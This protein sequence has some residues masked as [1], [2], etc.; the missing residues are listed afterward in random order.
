MDQKWKNFIIIS[1]GIF[2]STL[3]GSILNIANPVIANNFSVTID[4]VKWVTSS[5][6]MMITASLIFFGRLG[7]KAGSHRI[8][9]WGFLFFTLGSLCC[10]LSPSLSLLILSRVFQGIGASMLMA[11]G[12]GIISNSFPPHERGKALGLS[13]TIVGIGNMAGPSLG[14]LILAHFSWHTIFL[15]NI[16]F[17]VAAIILAMRFLEDQPKNP[18][19]IGFDLPG[20]AVF[21]VSVLLLI[22]SLSGSE[23][24]KVSLL[25]SFLLF[26]IF[27]CYLEKRSQHPMLDFSL[28]RVKPFVYGNIMA[29]AVY[30]IQTSMFFLMPFY[31]ETLL[32]LPSTTTGLLMTTLPVTMAIVAP[33]AGTL[34]DKIGSPKI[35]SLSFLILTIAY[36]VMANLS[37]KISFL[38]IGLGLVLVG[39][40]SSMFGSP[41]NSSILGS[42][43]REKAGYAGGFIATTR[44][45]G[46][47]IGIS[48]SASL[49]TYIQLEAQKTVAFT[50]AYVK[51]IHIVYLVA[52]GIAL[53]GFIF[54][55]FNQHAL[56]KKF[57]NS[58]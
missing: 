28:F 29:L 27:F 3:D 4:A 14:G 53:A 6:M 18:E 57:N 23:G 46:F 35:L 33:L 39:A 24:L 16:P 56:E 42:I 54:S 40:G 17:G 37:D 2:M 31:M 20:I 5:Y 50:L 55:L 38:H 15:I 49:F 10:S 34:S 11:T 19:I 51:G 22:T 30:M 26:A 58:E 32:K 45:L 44:N 7:D 1:F 25:L 52:A 47:A 36:I 21:S 48:A 43:P 9:T 12:M 41:N 13:G 8:Y